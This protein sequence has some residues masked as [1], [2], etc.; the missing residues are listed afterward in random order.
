MGGGEGV[1]SLSKIVNELFAEF[2]SRG[3]NVTIC[4]VCGRN[5]KLQK[6]LATRDW[7]KLLSKEER[8]RRFFRRGRRN[9]ILQ[10]GP[11]GRS[12]VPDLPPRGIVD[13]VGLGFVTNMADYMVAAD[14]LVTKAGP[15]SIAEAAAVG[16]PV[17]LTRYVNLAPQIMRPHPFV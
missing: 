6:D 3:L 7:G 12:T 5:E 15:G 4:V 13:V 11:D 8:Y 1:G 17:M 9:Q 14:V 10:S 2:S 16:L